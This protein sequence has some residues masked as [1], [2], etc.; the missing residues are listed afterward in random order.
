MRI[1]GSTRREG[2][3]ARRGSC[4]GR[5]RPGSA[6]FTCADTRYEIPVACRVT[7]ASPGGEAT[8]DDDGGVVR[9]DAGAGEAVPGL[10]RGPRPRQRTGQG[11]VMLR[12]SS[13]DRASGVV[14]GGEAGA[15]LQPSTQGIARS[16]YPDRADTIVHTEKGEVGWR[17]S[18][19]RPAAT[20]PLRAERG[21]L[22][23]CPAA[24]YGYGCAGRESCY[25]A[26][27]SQAGAFGRIV[28]IPLATQ[29]RRIFTPPPYGSP[30]WKRGSGVALRWN[31]STAAST[32]TSGSSGTSCAA[33][34]G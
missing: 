26:A 24:A 29:D 7:R 10:Q 25:R 6:G 32:T 18:R 22:K 3:T 11:E 20:D 27:G 12:H 33:A 28:R 19:K 4:G 30:S 15:G 2:R 17:L 14:E 9:G 13:L 21:T 23:Y 16:L 5:S 31:G 8:G 1:G 34:A